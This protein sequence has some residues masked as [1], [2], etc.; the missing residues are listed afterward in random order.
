MQE[1]ITD[2]NSYFVHMCMLRK[3]RLTKKPQT[4]AIVC[5]YNVFFQIE[6]T[7]HDK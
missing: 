4:T 3:A 5:S 7:K 2:S 6:N 1:N